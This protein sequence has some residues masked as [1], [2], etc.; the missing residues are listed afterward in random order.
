MS[1]SRPAARRYNGPLGILPAADDCIPFSWKGKQPPLQDPHPSHQTALWLQSWSWGQRL[2][3]SSTPTHFPAVSGWKC[4]IPWLHGPGLLCSQSLLS[5][6]EGASCQDNVLTRTRKEKPKASTK[7]HLISFSEKQEQRSHGVISF[8]TG[9]ENA[10]TYTP[11]LLQCPSTEISPSVT[12]E[13]WN[14]LCK[15]EIVYLSQQSWSNT[16]VTYKPPVI[17]VHGK[18]LSD[19]SCAANSYP[20]SQKNTP[21]WHCTLHLFLTQKGKRDLLMRIFKSTGFAR[22]EGWLKLSEQDLAPGQ[23]T[24]TESFNHDLQNC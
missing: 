8:M 18:T 14:L 11:H 19:C 24:I 15:W 1:H 7:W 17:L 10:I 3:G 22:K 20:C 4:P 12:D 6:S 16:E 2:P 5:F 21:G 23:Q 13:I 9:C